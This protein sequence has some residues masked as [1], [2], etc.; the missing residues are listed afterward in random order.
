MRVSIL[1]L[2][3]NVKLAHGYAVGTR[4]MDLVCSYERNYARNRTAPGIARGPESHGAR[5]RTGPGF[6][7][8]PESHG[9]RIPTAKPWVKQY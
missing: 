3:G 5:N 1:L 6:P 8:R 2:Y 9:S 4:D 7:R